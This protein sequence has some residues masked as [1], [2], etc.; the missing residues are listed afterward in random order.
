MSLADEA[1]D[2][3]VILVTRAPGNIGG[4]VTRALA[5]AGHPVRAGH[6]AIYERIAVRDADGAAAAR[7]LVAAYD[8][9]AARP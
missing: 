7:A 4:E 2:R 5:G 9:A 8:E 3:D 6:S 1:R